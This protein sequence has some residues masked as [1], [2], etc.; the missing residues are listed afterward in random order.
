MTTLRRTTETQADMPGQRQYIS[1]IHKGQKPS[2]PLL[3]SIILKNFNFIT[4]QAA[5]HE[6]VRSQR[7]YMSN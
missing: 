6:H 7:Q 5:V 1:K 4:S 3:L 2:N